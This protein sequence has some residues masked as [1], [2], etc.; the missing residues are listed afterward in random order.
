M[1]L[2]QP[3]ITGSLSVSGSVN[4]SGSI[5][6]AGGGTISGTASIAT[7]ALTAS[8]ADNLLVRNTLTAQTLVV[9]TITSSVDFVT[10]STRFGSIAANTHNFTG[11]VLVSGSFGLNKAVPQRQYTQ[12]ANA[13]GIVF[14]IQN[15]S[16]SN[17]GYIVGF[18]SIGSTY[19]QLSDST[20]AAKVYLNS[21]GSSY[22][23]GGN[24]GIGTASPTSYTG[25]SVL[26]INNS[27]YGGLI[28]LQYGGTSGLRISTE[29]TGN[30]FWG[31]TNI[32]ML[33]ATN[34]TERMRI[35]AGGNLQLNGVSGTA[36]ITTDSSANVMG[37]FTTS[38]V[39]DGTPRIE[40]TGTTYPSTPS[41]AFIRANTVRFTLNAAGT[42]TMR[43]TSAGNIGV[44]E[45]SPSSMLHFSKQTTWGTTDNR[46]ININNSGTGGNINIAHNMGSIT[47]YSGNSTPTAEIA[48]YRNTPASGNNIELRFYTATAGTPIESM[49]I[50]SGGVITKQY[51]PLAMGA[52]ADNQ[53]VA[54]TTFT[55]IAFNTSFGFN[56]ANVGSCWNNGTS[57][58]T[59]PATGTYLINAG[60]YTNNVGQIAAF[61]NGNRNISMVSTTGT[62]P[63]TW[64]GTIMVELSSGDALTLRGYGDSSGTVYQNT[65]H[66]WFGIYFLG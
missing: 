52:M 19:L 40:V 33:F 14:T 29:N 12:V 6:I 53:S 56:Q 64:H 55:S 5:S 48:A 37:L 31:A 60:L 51:Q 23:T 26:T 28:D 42:E 44:N 21:S 43:I 13:N 27:T 46:I 63:T 1:N 59:A 17:E 32:P 18:D 36:A 58:F 30:T 25:Y 20:N 50:S 9:Q 47:W 11:S 38:S 24:V 15:A 66:T 45:T 35:T 49:R 22:F 7:T 61:V 34:A 4:I 62:F 57:T 2:Y 39:V 8:S 65:Y 10:G 54:A 16:A 3:T 41:T